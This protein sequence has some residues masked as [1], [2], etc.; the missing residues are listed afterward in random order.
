MTRDIVALNQW[1]DR[2]ITPVL[3][4][5]VEPGTVD[6]DLQVKDSLPLHGSVELNNR[7][8]PN[9]T[10]LRVNGA[11][12]YNNLWQKGHAAGVSFQVAPEDVDNAKVLSAYYQARIP[13]VRLG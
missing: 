3:R 5:G 13:A 9:T 8:S 4:A 2:R 1:P 11:V 10:E 7:Y 12:S 6:I